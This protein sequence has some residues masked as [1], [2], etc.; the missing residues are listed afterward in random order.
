MPRAGPRSVPCLVLGLVVLVGAT[1]FYGV[2]YT[3]AYRQPH[4]A[5]RASEW[6]NSHAP[7]G[8]VIL[9]EHWEEGLPDLGRYEVRELPMYERDDRRK[10]E[11]VSNE[12]AGADYVV[13]YSNRLY[14]TIPAPARTLPA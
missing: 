3:S 5:V 8:A 9:K 6:I 1:A 12:L 2:A 11:R 7:A 10:L 13:F 14:G 4:T